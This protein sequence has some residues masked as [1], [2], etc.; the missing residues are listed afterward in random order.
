MKATN[1]SNKTTVLYINQDTIQYVKKTAGGIQC[2]EIELEEGTVLNG[3]I[4]KEAEILEKLGTIAK[5]LHG[6]PITLVIDSS[7]MMFKKIETP[8]MPVKHL[9]SVLRGEFEVVNEDNY[10]YDYS[11]LSSVK[12]QGHVILGTVAQKEF[13]QKYLD[14]FK[15]AKIKLETIDIALNG[16]VKF[17]YQN[18]SLNRESFILN[19]V[20]KN[21]M[22]LSILFENGKYE[23]INRYRLIQEADT[24]P[25][26]NELF[27]KLSSMIQFNNSKSTEYQV[28]T[29]YYVGVSEDTLISLATYAD[30]VD[31]RISPFMERNINN[32][33]FYACCGVHSLKKD[34]D[35]QIAYKLSKKKVRASSKD[36]AQI[37][38]VLG[39]AL[40]VGSVGY[41][42]TSQN[43]K[44][45]AQIDPLEKFVLSDDVLQTKI[46]I[47]ELTTKKNEYESK[48]AEYNLIGDNVAE[49]RLLN[50]EKIRYIYNNNMNIDAMKYDIKER[51][52]SI[53]GHYNGYSAGSNYADVLRGSGYFDSVSY[54]GYSAANNL[55]TVSVNAVVARP[56]IV[57]EIEDAGEVTPNE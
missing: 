50:T 57:E 51:N 21:N 3:V 55:L 35:L 54:T 7:N 31:V 22:M 46:M 42:L 32:S 26:V 44:L 12:K 18:S 1:K 47:A 48:I 23:L 49:G 20:A 28:R 30:E 11:I 4:V 43:N 25:Y 19:I 8:N 45:Q 29:S 5:Q 40:A 10:V 2:T 56:V 6:K 16:I 34:I 14:L 9:S 33:C 36:T 24:E 41:Y 38:S 37:L 15:Q 39:V 53:N 17:V 52:V 13:I 27:S